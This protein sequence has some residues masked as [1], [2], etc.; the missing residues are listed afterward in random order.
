MLIGHW[1]W[2]QREA[3]AGSPTWGAFL[4]TFTRVFE[5][6]LYQV[7][8]KPM[9][10]PSHLWWT[11][12]GWARSDVLGIPAGRGKVVAL[13]VAEAHTYALVDDRGQRLLSHNKLPT[14]NQA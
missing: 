2:S 14:Q 7:D 13:T 9:S 6:D 8:G 12:E 11:A 4:V 5:S 3:E 10:S 1:V